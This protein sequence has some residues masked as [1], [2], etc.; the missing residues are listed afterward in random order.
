MAGGVEL[1]VAGKRGIPG[2]QGPQGSGAIAVFG[3]AGVAASATLRYLPPGYQNATAPTTR[4]DVR[5]AIDEQVDAISFFCR[6]PHLGAGTITYTL[7]KNG[8]LTGVAV[9]VPGGVQSARFVLGAPV[10]YSAA[11][12][13]TWGIV[14]TKA[15]AIMSS[16]LDP[17]IMIG[18][19]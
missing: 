6:S 17:M 14:V 11:A 12:G 4:V 2:P 1:F 7:L 5:V 9:A 19:T 3:A 8:A 10:S 16:P 18:K 13:D 15:G